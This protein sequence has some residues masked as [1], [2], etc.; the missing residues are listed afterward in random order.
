MSIQVK[1]LSQHLHEICLYWSKIRCISPSWLN[2][3]KDFQIK[4]RIIKLTALPPWTITCLS[5]TG[6]G[7]LA[8]MLSVNQLTFSNLV[9]CGSSVTF[10]TFMAWAAVSYSVIMWVTLSLQYWK[11]ITNPMNVLALSLS[12]S[13][14]TFSFYI[15]F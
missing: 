5:W 3:T 6:T 12:L 13:L 14:L 10:S 9:C 2:Q 15:N 1:R 7:S 4:F 11:L 8:L